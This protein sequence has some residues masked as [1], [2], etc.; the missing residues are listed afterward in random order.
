M[1]RFVTLFV[2]AHIVLTSGLAAQTKPPAGVAVRTMTTPLLLGVG[3]SDGT[4]AWH[5]EIELYNVARRAG[6]NVVMLAY[7][8][9]DDGWIT[10][11]QS[12]LDRDAEIKREKAGR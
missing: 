7:M 3:D 6:K 12:Y 2:P 4:V 1:K 10:E 5:Q 9:E 11:G 8:G